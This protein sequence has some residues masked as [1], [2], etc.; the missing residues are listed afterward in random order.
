MTSANFIRYEEIVSAGDLCEDSWQWSAWKRIYYDSFPENERMSE[1]YFLQ[2]FEEKARGEGHDKHMLIMLESQETG[3]VPVGMSY[4]E[5]DRELGVGFLWYLAIQR[6]SRNKGYGTAFYAELIKRAKSDG[7]RLLAFE[8]EIP[9]LAAAKSAENAEWARRRIAW[10]RR[11][12][13]FVLEGVEYYQEV[14]TGVAPTRMFLMLHP[15]API[16]AEQGFSLARALFPDTL[17]QT[18][19][20]KLA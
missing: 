15:L 20:L 10:Y 2:M 6:E 19:P 3:T 8:V 18:G 4:H 17:Q 5:F 9:E 16:D 12:G 7:A 14:D 13:A 11:Q 1:R